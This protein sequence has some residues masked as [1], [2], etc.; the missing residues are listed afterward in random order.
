MMLIHAAA[1]VAVHEQPVSVLTVTL[2]VPA[3]ESKDAL[4]AESAK[5]QGAT[6]GKVVAF[7]MLE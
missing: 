1:L 2:P 5:E 3:I 4:V 6:A 7:A